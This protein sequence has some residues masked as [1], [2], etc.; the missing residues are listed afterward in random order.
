MAEKAMSRDDVIHLLFEKDFFA[1][2]PA[3][4]DIAQTVNECKIAY[5]NDSYNRCCGGWP[6]LMFPAID[7]LFSKLRE[8]KETDPASVAHFCRFIQQRRNYSE[9]QFLIYYR[10]DTKGRPERLALP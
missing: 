5:V 2:N 1:A 10:K 3:L 4:A 9:Q 7:A 8:L 6:G